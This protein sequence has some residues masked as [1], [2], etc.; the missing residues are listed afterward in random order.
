[1]HRIL[2]DKIYIGLIENKKEGTYADGEH[3]AIIS[4][5]L[6]NQVQNALANNSNNKTTSSH[7][8]NILTGKLFDHKGVKFINQRTSGK[9]K[10]NVHYYAIKGFY[11]PAPRVDDVVIKTIIDDTTATREYEFDNVDDQIF[12]EP[13]VSQYTLRED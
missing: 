12:V 9:G 3:E 7:A 1:M 13:D 10:K 11:L 4:K 5:D 6:F 2:R 8:P